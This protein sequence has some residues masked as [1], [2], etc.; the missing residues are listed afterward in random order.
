M[1]FHHMRG[2]FL[3]FLLLCT[4][5]AAVDSPAQV[6]IAG[7][8]GIAAVVNNDVITVSQVRDLSGVRE[9]S[10]QEMYSG[11]ELKRR[12]EE[13]RKAAIN[14]LI[15]RQLVLQ[16]F[17]KLQKDRG[18]SIPDYI[19][20][21]R[22]ATVI[23]EEFGGDRAAFVRTL[24]AQGYTA[25]QFR[26]I[27]RDKVV[28]QAMRS[29]FAKDDFV[30]SPKAVEKFYVQNRQTWAS[31]EQIKLRMIVL[32]NDDSGESKLPIAREIRE[33][34]V[35]GADFARMAEV[36]SEDSTQDVGGD[37]GWIG[38]D[39]LNRQLSDVAFSLKAGEVSDVLEMGGSFYILCVE[40]RKNATV[41]PLSDV[42][43]EIERRLAQEERG[44]VQDRWIS[45][46][47]EK[48]YIKVY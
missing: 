37:W 21:D 28:V 7:T 3:P 42:R 18:A 36:Y 16:E 47:R 46:L 5:L 10:L 32:R 14:D 41:K 12:V 13:S 15:D 24:K 11:E 19:I 8:D 35:T 17:K 38:R 29:Q 1:N 31:P 43:E 9:R 20:D 6:H 30:I 34:L 22:V 2:R 44:K 4:A 26:E 48:A 39:T 27:E 25:T 33:K 40:A 23:R 45:Q